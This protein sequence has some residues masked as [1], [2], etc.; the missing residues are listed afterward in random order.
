[1]GN[2]RKFGAKG[3]NHQRLQRSRRS[4]RPSSAGIALALTPPKPERENH[5]DSFQ[6][7]CGAE[8]V[9]TFVV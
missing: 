2:A 6:P 7:A 8:Q 1:M 4:A 3:V 5:E 9:V